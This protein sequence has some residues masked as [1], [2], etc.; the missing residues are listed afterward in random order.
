MGLACGQI[1]KVYLVGAGPGDPQLLTLKAARIIEAAT[2]VVYDRLVS[3]AILAMVP[4]GAARIDV[5]KRPQHHPVPQEEI[6][7]T[8][9]GLAK[10]GRT[11]VRL[12]GGD[13]FL[14][15]RG[16]EEAAALAVASVPFEVVPGITSAQGG[17]AAL[18]FPLTHRGLATGVRYVTG[19]CRAGEALAL[20]WTGLADAQTTL[21]V[22]MG[23][24]SI[25]LIVSELIRHGRSPDTP[26]L[27]V[28]RATLPDQRE[29]L[30]TLATLTDAVAAEHLTSPTLII[31]GEV[32]RLARITGH[33]GHAALVEQMAAA[34]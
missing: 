8:L 20:D 17:A 26:A 18:Q 13:P 5:G 29:A 19:H 10:A 24:A 34:P 30:A 6:N 16:G 15:G 7:R 4:K 2:V 3:D 9:I 25:D 12:K 14:F 1:G 23:L 32:T 11:V 28:S 22:Y 21:V 33:I 27:A 31:I